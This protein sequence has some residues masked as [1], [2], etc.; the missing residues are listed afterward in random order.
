VRGELFGVD[1][2]GAAPRRQL[3]RFARDVVTASAPGPEVSSSP[4]KQDFVI[5]KPGALGVTSRHF[6]KCRNL[7]NAWAVAGKS[8]AH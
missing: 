1:A 5:S 6:S 7:T 3:S 8:P 4:L 2:C